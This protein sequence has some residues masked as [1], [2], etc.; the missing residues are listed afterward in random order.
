MEAQ[1]EGLPRV[2]VA[3]ANAKLSL[4]RYRKDLELKSDVLLALF[5]LMTFGSDVQTCN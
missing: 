4:P 2:L 3:K 1:V 5:Y